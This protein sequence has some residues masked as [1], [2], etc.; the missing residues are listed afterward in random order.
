MYAFRHFFKYYISREKFFLTF[1]TN[2]SQKNVLKVLKTCMFKKPVNQGKVRYLICEEKSWKSH[3]FGKMS[4]IS[5]EISVRG[6][7]NN[8]QG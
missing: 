3:G 5:Q 2:F 1:F 7:L 4:G 6:T 8:H